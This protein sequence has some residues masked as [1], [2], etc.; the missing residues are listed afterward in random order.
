MA[1]LP[2]PSPCRPGARDVVPGF[3]TYYAMTA[4]PE[5]QGP[6][7]PR[8]AVSAGLAGWPE[9][10][11][12]MGADLRAGQFMAE[13]PWLLVATPTLADPGRAPAGQHT[14][15]LLSPQAYDPPGDSG[16]AAVKHEHARRT[17]ELAPSGEGRVVAVAGDPP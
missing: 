11:I 16:W 12:Q 4:A 8:S 15:K 7:G 5:F 17:L 1:R 13:P 3:A 6:D 10:V 14:V 2:R 9:D